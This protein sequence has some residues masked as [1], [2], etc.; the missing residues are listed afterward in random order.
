MKT[1]EGKTLVATL[2]VYLNALPARASTSSPS[3]I[4]S[5]AATPR[6]W[7]GLRFLG[8]TDG[9]IVHGLSDDERRAAYACDD[10]TY[11]PTTNSAS[12]ICATT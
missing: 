7:P 2:P 4:T 12:I 9:V 11:A 10:I 5:P 3:T 6:G 1:G 8:L